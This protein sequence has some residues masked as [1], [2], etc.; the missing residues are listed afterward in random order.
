MQS[1][2]YHKF[3]EL[4]SHK[5][6]KTEVMILYQYI[7]SEV[8]L[9]HCISAN[10]LKFRRNICEEPS[11]LNWRF[12]VVSEFSKI[13]LSG[14][15]MI[16]NLQLEF[17]KFAFDHLCE[18]ALK[19]CLKGF[20]ANAVSFNPVPWRCEKEVTFILQAVGGR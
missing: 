7:M 16:I 18:E 2:S 19:T 10:G 12:T 13:S 6:R 20:N 5:C 15:E 11:L 3:I 17:G 9:V 1:E 8:I 4:L 14:S